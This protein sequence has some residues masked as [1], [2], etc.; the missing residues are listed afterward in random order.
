MKLCGGTE[1][2]QIF[3]MMLQSL[4]QRILSHIGLARCE[5]RLEFR[6]W[7]NRVWTDLEGQHK[8][9]QRQRQDDSLHCE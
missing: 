4:T 2:L 6:Q 5:H 7:S 8:S 3:G 1:Q 9:E